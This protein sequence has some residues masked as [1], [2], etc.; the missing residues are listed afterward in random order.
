MNLNEL[1]LWEIVLPVFVQYKF[2]I[3]AIVF[4]FEGFWE[5][6]SVL[7]VTDNLTYVLLFR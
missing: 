7:L 4:H 3:D 2:I 5:E 6:L 1:C